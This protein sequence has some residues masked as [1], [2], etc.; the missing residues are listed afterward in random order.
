MKPRIEQKLEIKKSEY[1]AMMNWIKLKGGKIIFP[2]RIICST[3]FDNFKRDMFF[4]TNE[5]LI[6]R[7]KIR[8]RT[9]NTR[10]FLNSNSKYNLEIKLTTENKRYKEIRKDIEPLKFINQGIHDCLYGICLPLIE[11]SYTREYFKIE[12]FRL[13]ID[14]DIVYRT[15]FNGK[16]NFNNDINDDYYVVE[17][18]TDIN[19]DDDYIRNLFEF[20]RSKFSKYERGVEAL[21]KTL[22]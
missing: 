19:Q 11:I 18:K 15:P 16:D 14:K 22:I 10:N 8:I 2:E 6:P 7:K 9:Y 1:F 20:P 21:Y 13:T 17:I 12:N 4:D 3:Y 5:G